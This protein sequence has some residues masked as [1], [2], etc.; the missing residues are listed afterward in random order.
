MGGH[1]SGGKDGKR[2]CSVFTRRFT[3]NGSFIPVPAP[4][5][6]ASG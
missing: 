4:S 1:C 5:A 2:T 3:F 6:L